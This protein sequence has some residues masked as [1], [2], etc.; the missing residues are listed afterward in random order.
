MVRVWQE[1]DPKAALMAGKRKLIVE[2][3]L[4]SFLDEGYAES[5]VNR[6]AAEAGV[7]IK[8][9]YRH[10]DSKDD[11]FSA[12]ME[13]ACADGAAETSDEPAWLAEPPPTGL[14]LAGEDY[15]RHA[16]SVDQLAL[17]RVVMQDAHRFPELGRRYRDEIVGRRAALFARYL[18]RW[19]P[20]TGWKVADWE[21]AGAVFEGLLKAGLF[22]E[23]LQGGPQPDEAEIIRR[24]GDAAARLQTLFE[25]RLL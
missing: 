24:A 18:D 12:V 22:D 15:L 9:L 4:R 25:A 16:L 17:Y 20:S 3:A 10:F 6:I 11:L 1:D 19:L 7:S 13:A 14:A 2:A 23:L 5:S 21:A 8:T